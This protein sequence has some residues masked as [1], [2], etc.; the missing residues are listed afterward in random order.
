MIT[1]ATVTLSELAQP[2]R[3]LRLF[4]DL[5][6]SV[7][8]LGS[9]GVVIET[10][11][12]LPAWKQLFDDKRH[13]DLII[14]GDQAQRFYDTTTHDDLLAF[15]TWLIA[16][17]DVAV[18]PATKIF[19]DK[20]RT[21]VGPWQ[22][23][24]VFAEAGFVTELPP[25]ADASSPP[26]LLLSERWLWTGQQW[27]DGQSL[28]R[29]GTGSPVPPTQARPPV[30]TFLS[31]NGEVVKIELCRPDF[32]DDSE[33]NREVDVLTSLWAQDIPDISLPR[34]IDHHRGDVVSVM[35]R[36]ALD[37]VVLT[38]FLHAH[39]LAASDVAAA[40][41]SFAASLARRGI[42]HND[43]RPWNLLWH[44]GE[45]KAV[46]YSRMSEEENDARSLPNILALVGTLSWISQ[47]ARDKTQVSLFDEFDGDIVSVLSPHLG[48]KGIALA[49]LYDQPWR[50]FGMSN[51]RVSVAPDMSLE[52]ITQQLLP[53]T[54][55]MTQ[56]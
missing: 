24:P 56:A 1:I 37:G 55:D 14:I 3:V 50:E 11:P 41:V 8:D 43:F 5:D 32:F 52:D 22:A 47:C 49:D 48:Q 6:P 42:F 27:F 36:G 51:A 53:P 46:D 26:L 9:Q 30:R 39:P 15:A 2:A 23:A 10:G 18:I 45:V 16:H 19:L 31:A 4:G 54:R 44:N 28:R 33:V 17:G 40:T 13:W 20:R 25:P 21:D 35:V 38:E 12:A 7:C 34:V 29:A